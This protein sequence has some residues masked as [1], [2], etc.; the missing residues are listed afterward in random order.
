MLR[1]EWD[2]NKDRENQRKHG[3][4]FKVA[5]YAFSDPHRIIARDLEHS[6]DERRF[7]CFGRTGGGILTVRFTHRKTNIRI[8]GAGYWRDG[9]KI[10]EEENQ[11]HE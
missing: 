8:F 5:Q 7:Y 11:I 6:K 1:F 10:Y 4:S 3:V 2:D 9:R